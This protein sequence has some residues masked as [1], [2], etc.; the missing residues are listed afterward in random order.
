[1]VAEIMRVSTEGRAPKQTPGIFAL[2]LACRL[3]DQP[4]KAA[5]YAALGK[6][7]RTASTLFDF[8]AYSKAVNQELATTE[9]RTV[10]NASWGRGM[11]HAVANWYLDKSALSLAYQVRRCIRH[12]TYHAD[13]CSSLQTCVQTGYATRDQVR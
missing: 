8:L 7:A 5:A 9:G 6:V 3:G 4:T 1:M 11:R 2:A 12:S 10:N 13:L